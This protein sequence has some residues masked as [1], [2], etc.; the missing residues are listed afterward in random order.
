[1]VRAVHDIAGQIEEID[2]VTEL[3]MGAIERQSQS[4]HGIAS[5]VEDATKETE[6]IRTAVSNVVE[7]S[8]KTE[9]AAKLVDQAQGMLAKGSENIAQIVRVFLA[10]I[11]SVSAS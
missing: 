2:K 6:I 4:T 5:S 7:S 10:N 8:E 11:K 3:M 9:Q 1:M